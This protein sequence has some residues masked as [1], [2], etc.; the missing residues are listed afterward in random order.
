VPLALV[1]AAAGCGSGSDAPTYRGNEFPDRPV[2][3]GFTLRD[4]NG[5]IVTLSGFRGK[6]VLLT[7]LYTWCPDVCPVI[8]GNLNAAL[9]APVAKRM[10]LNVLSVSVDPA[11]DTPAAARKYARDHRLLPTFTWLLGTP[12]ELAR[13]WKAYDIAVLPGPKNTV[14]HAAIQI[15]IDPEGH[16]RLFYDAEVQTADVVA[17]LRTLEDE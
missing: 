15:L 2:A 17:D 12:A 8:A 11:R 13:V 5:K 7:F 1:L 6:W 9:R 10:G 4:E 16:E 3:T 14:S